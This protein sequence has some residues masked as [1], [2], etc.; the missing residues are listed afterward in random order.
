MIDRRR[1]LAGAAALGLA[2]PALCAA[3][4]ARHQGLV[5]ML[6]H[7]VTEPGI[8]DPPG[9]RLDDCRSQRNLSAEGRLQAQRLGE[10]LAAQ[11]LR[12]TRVRSSRWCRCLDTARL[13]FGGVEPWPALDSFFDDRGR[14]PAQTAALREALPAVP[15]GEVQAWVTHQVNIS[16]LAGASTAMGEALV[17]R[18]E[19]LRDGSVRVVQLG[20]IDAGAGG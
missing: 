3:F 10:R 14:E 8:G 12:P 2:P 20:R 9:Y 19:R 18:G 17:L 6:R 15:P 5:V 7:A 4:D 13:A 11:G 16:A 1:L